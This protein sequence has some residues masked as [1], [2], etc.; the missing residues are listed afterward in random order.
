MVL[1]DKNNAFFPEQPPATTL[2]AFFDANQDP[3]LLGEQAQQLLYQE[4][5]QEF[6]WMDGECQRQV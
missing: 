1:F 5:P 6:W 4:F 2:T 3:G